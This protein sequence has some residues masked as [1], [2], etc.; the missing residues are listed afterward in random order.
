MTYQEE[1][2]LHAVAGRLAIGDLTA[3]YGRAYDGN[4]LGAWL[5]CFTQEAVF[6]LPDGQVFEGHKGLAEFFR[7]APHDMVHLTTDAVA[8]V[9]GVRARQESHVLVYVAGGEPVVRFVG[10]YRD[11][12]IYERGS[13]YFTRRAITR[14]L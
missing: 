11:E 9:D 6:E 2:T 7:G 4:D 12:L 10:T 1:T 13:W 14:D 3:R 8:E 5:G